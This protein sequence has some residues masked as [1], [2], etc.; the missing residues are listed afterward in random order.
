MPTG[1][2]MRSEQELLHR[3]GEAPVCLSPA[4]VTI[5]Q[6]SPVLALLSGSCWHCYS[7]SFQTKLSS[8]ELMLILH[9]A[10]EQ[11]LDSRTTKE[12]VRLAFGG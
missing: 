10:N 6:P 7:S 2:R 11:K 8:S 5:I 3:T 9:Y 12:C 4:L 1:L